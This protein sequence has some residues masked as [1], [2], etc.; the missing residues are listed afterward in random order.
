M[1]QEND[2]WHPTK[3]DYVRLEKQVVDLIIKSHEH[4]NQIAFL[5]ACMAFVL[6]YIGLKLLWN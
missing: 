5:F 2:Q 6:V 3:D 1:A 4:N